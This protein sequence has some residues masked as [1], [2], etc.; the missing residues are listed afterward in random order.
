MGQSKDPEQ[1]L[2]GGVFS[3]WRD[4]EEERDWAD[5]MR[6]TPADIPLAIQAKES[7][8]RRFSVVRCVVRPIPD[9]DS[10]G[11]RTSIPGESEHGFRPIPNTGSG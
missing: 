3:W 4:P 5:E 7:R 10:G 9:S 1:P 8:F 2:G 6:R 11:I